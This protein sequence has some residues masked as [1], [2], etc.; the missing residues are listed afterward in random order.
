MA[1]LSLNG[2]KVLSNFHETRHC[3][4]CHPPLGLMK[5]K[6]KKKFPQSGNCLWKALWNFWISFCILFACFLLVH[7]AQEWWQIPT[8]IW[9]GLYWA[10]P[11]LLN[12]VFRSKLTLTGVH[13]AFPSS[14]KSTEMGSAP[15]K[16]FISF[17][18]H[19]DHPPPPQKKAYF[20]V[21]FKSF[22]LSV[23]FSLGLIKS[24][25]WCLIAH[26]SCKTRGLTWACT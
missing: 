12:Q 24:L 10:A 26:D 15:W 19:S 17:Q 20:L 3:G 16:G 6:W 22:L 11:P 7:V 1:F 14:I 2:C 23:L 4:Y 18:N 13:S 8:I 9:K 5:W 21:K 25:W